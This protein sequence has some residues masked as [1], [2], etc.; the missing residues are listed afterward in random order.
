MPIYYKVD[1]APYKIAIKDK[2]WHNNDP[3]AM[4]DWFNKKKDKDCHLIDVIKYLKGW[5]D[6]IG[7]MPS[8]LSMTILA[9]NA[10]NKLIFGDRGDI[11]LADTLKEIKKALDNKFECIVPVEPNDNLFEDYDSTKKEKFLNAL[12]DFIADADA[13]LRED[14]QL[15]A[16]KLWRK[17][18]GDRVPLGED[19]TEDK[20]SNSK[21]IAG[22]GKSSPYGS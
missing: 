22:I 4:V 9:S 12:K 7:N 8:G 2:D 3:K 14:N 16:S 18:L 6:F 1:G 11:N 20:T 5:C 19:K 21:L 17:H 13:A 10:K 15:K